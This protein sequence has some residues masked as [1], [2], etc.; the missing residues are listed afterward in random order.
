MRLAS[1]VF[2]AAELA[3]LGPAGPEVEEF[4]VFL[5]GSS[6]GDWYNLKR[7]VADTP[8]RAALIG[9]CVAEQLAMGWGQI[10]VYRGDEELFGMQIR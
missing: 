5:R 9:Q 2:G 7:V 4:R 8:L 1:R 3:E 6:T 10:C